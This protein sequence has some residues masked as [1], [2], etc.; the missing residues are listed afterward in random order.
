MLLL[1]DVETPPAEAEDLRTRRILEVLERA[2]GD[3]AKGML[4]ELAGGAGGAWLTE[5]AK[6]ALKRLEAR[7]GK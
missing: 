5:E 1:Q 4:K 2:G 6:A 3:D 7:Q